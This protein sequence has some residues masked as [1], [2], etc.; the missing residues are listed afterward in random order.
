MILLNTKSEEGIPLRSD[1]V[2]LVV[3]SPPYFNVRGDGGL[4]DADTLDIYLERLWRTTS[5]VLR[6]LKPEGSAFI[7]LG[8]RYSSPGG[9]M[10]NA[11]SPMASGA[12][13]RV[14]ARYG[15]KGRYGDI[16]AKC[17]MGIPQRFQIGCIDGRVGPC[18]VRAEIIWSKAN[19][20]PEGS[21]KQRVWR[22]HETWYHLTKT[23]QTFAT[24]EMLVP[25]KTPGRKPRPPGSVWD[26]G[27]DTL[28]VP[29]DVLA[30]LGIE[31]H[32]APFPK[33]WPLRFIRGYS[34][35]N[36]V[37]LDPFMGSGTT[38]VAAAMLGRRCI[39][40]DLYRPYLGLA[41]WRV[42]EYHRDGI[43]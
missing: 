23:P 37:V 3:T 34:P 21:E 10:R 4:G 17:L 27:P 7:N 29:K 12:A 22:S 5:E 26:I 38:G 25:A 19:P 16:P 18:W 24:E 42:E 20:M 36:G 8:D 40:L 1:S 33:E 39:G 2:D 35:P 14:G 32:D 15:Q 6:V 31:R 11:T 28:K 13:S 9:A 41:Q 43:A 30:R